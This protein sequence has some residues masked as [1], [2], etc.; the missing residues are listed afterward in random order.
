MRLRAMHTR[1]Q[2]GVN[3]R[4]IKEAECKLDPKNRAHSAIQI[5][6]RQR[7]FADALDQ[8]LLKDIVREVVELHVHAGADGEARGVLGRCGY[9]MHGV[10]TLDGPEVGENEALEP[11]L[12]PK[13][14]LEQEWV[15]RDG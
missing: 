8:R 14:C 4:M 7:A 3:E 1:I 12:V 10:K 5:R 11:P 13:N 15:C 9:M 2:R 6:L